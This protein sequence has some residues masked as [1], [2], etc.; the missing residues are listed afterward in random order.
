[1]APRQSPDLSNQSALLFFNRYKGCECALVVY[2]AAQAQVEG[3]TETARGG[4]QVVTIDLDRRPDIGNQYGVVRAPVL[5]LIDSG[6]NSIY[7][8]DKVIADT[9]PLD[10]VHF[11]EAIKEYQHGN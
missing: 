6:G 1:M 9:A 2:E 3:W 10:L 7:R 5:I 11:E 4:I 8:Q